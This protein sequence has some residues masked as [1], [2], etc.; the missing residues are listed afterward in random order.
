MK[1]EQLFCCPVC[2]GVLDRPREAHFEC[3]T[4]ELEFAK[5]GDVYDFR[6][7]PATGAARWRAGLADRFATGTGWFA[8]V[9]RHYAADEFGRIL[10]D[11][12]IQEIEAHATS[13]ADAGVDLGERY[14]RELLVR[15]S[16]RDLHELLIGLRHVPKTRR[17]EVA[18]DLGCGTLR[19][20][21][22]LLERGF[23]SVIAVDLLPEMM[24]YGLTKLPPD[25][26]DRVILVAADARFLPIVAGAIDLTFSLDFFEHID[27]PLLLLLDVK[28][29]LAPGG[30]AVINTWNGAG[31]SYRSNIRSKGRSY[32][33]NGFFYAFHRRAE[34]EEILRRIGVEH[35]VRPYGF[36]GGRRL[37]H[38]IGPGML[39]PAIAADGLLSHVLPA[40][41][42][43]FLMLSF[44][45]NEP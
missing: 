22:K 32:Y 41:L 18:L 43:P 7:R 42:F 38:L 3:A 23:G 28:R 35:R 16:V 30:A 4:C 17:R 34:V 19:A 8:E 29:V 10:A 45:G 2:K 1:V 11:R 5:K 14:D 13:L 33:A 31:L 36:Y 37:A 12:R 39:R 9:R 26:R 25:Q 20:P 27:P 44:R 40:S 6:V 24:E 21:K 15:D